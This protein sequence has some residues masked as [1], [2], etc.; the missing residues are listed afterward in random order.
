MMGGAQQTEGT[1][2]ISQGNTGEGTVLGKQEFSVD[3]DDQPVRVEFGEGAVHIEPGE[4]YSI[5][6]EKKRGANSVYYGQHGQPVA[7]SDGSGISFKFHN[8]SKARN[9]GTGVSRGQIPW[10]FCRRP[11]LRRVTPASSSAGDVLQKFE[12]SATLDVNP[13]V[14]C[15]FVD[16]DDFSELLRLLSWAMGALQTVVTPGQSSLA[17]ATVRLC[18]RL[19]MINVPYIDDICGVSAP[20]TSGEAAGRESDVDKRAGLQG[21][22]GNPSSATREVFDSSM[23]TKAEFETEDEDSSVTGEEMDESENDNEVARR[24][25]TS[26]STKT[27]IKV[28]ALSQQGSAGRAATILWE[29]HRLLCS[30][31]QTECG[32]S[33]DLLSTGAETLSCMACSAYETM[34]YALFPRPVNALRALIDRLHE[35][36]QKLA[37]EKARHSNEASTH[38]ALLTSTL[39]SLISQGWGRHLAHAWANSDNSGNFDSK[40]APTDISRALISEALLSLDERDS[41]SRSA[42]SLAREEPAKAIGTCFGSAAELADQLLD[43]VIVPASQALAAVQTQHKEFEATDMHFIG[44]EASCTS[45]AAQLLVDCLHVLT[46]DAKRK[47][48]ENAQRKTADALDK[49]STTKVTAAAK[50]AAEA[51]SMRLRVAR[52]LKGGSSGSWG[53]GGQPDEIQFSLVA[54]PSQRPDATVELAGFGLFGTSGSNVFDATISL[55]EVADGGGVFG[56][57]PAPEFHF[58][59][60]GAVDAPRGEKLAEA[61]VRFGDHREQVDAAEAAGKAD[62]NVF[63][64]MFDD[65]VQLQ[66][67]VTYCAVAHISGQSSD[68]G[69]RIMYETFYDSDIEVDE[70][71][72]KS[73]RRH[74]QVARGGFSFGEVAPAQEELSGSDDDI[75]EYDPGRP[76]S[77]VVGSDGARFIFTN[78]GSNNGTDIN[79]GQIPQLLYRTLIAADATSQIA[80]APSQK[81]PTTELPSAVSG[82]AKAAKGPATPAEESDHWTWNPDDKSRHVALHDDDTS[83][84]KEGG[85]TDG[86]RGTVAFTPAGGGLHSFELHWNCGSGSNSTVGFATSE[87]PTHHDRYVDQVGMDSNGWGMKA[88]TG[89]LL[90]GGRSTGRGSR[91]QQ[92]SYLAVELDLD[93]RPAILR[94]GVR[95]EEE[96]EADT[97]HQMELDV[98]AM[99]DGEDT[100]LF[101]MISTSMASGK[102]ILLSCHSTWPLRDEPATIASQTVRLADY[103]MEAPPAM[104]HTPALVSFCEA[105]FSRTELLISDALDAARTDARSAK[106]IVSNS[107]LI[108]RLL[109]VVAPTL[110]LMAAGVTNMNATDARYETVLSASREGALLAQSMLP[111][112]E[113]LLSQFTAL[114]D[115]TN[116]GVDT[117]EIMNSTVRGGDDTRFEFETP[118]P[119]EPSAVYKWEAH[120][121]ESVHFISVHFD[122]RCST[123]QSCDTL[124]LFSDAGAYRRPIGPAMSGCS[125]DVSKALERLADE[126]EAGEKQDK[127]KRKK[128]KKKKK[129]KKDKKKEGSATYGEENDELENWPDGRTAPVIVAGRHICAEFSSAAQSKNVGDLA[130]FDAVDDNK[131]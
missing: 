66:T 91:F 62:I 126:A 56:G 112:L 11:T 65:P 18:I 131:D 98:D 110:G 45:A 82:Q 30:V 16:V 123:A 17:R 13:Q 22:G 81:V 113:K 122:Q 51:S 115:S 101:P 125:V 73:F 89:D 34:F 44:S 4:K 77:A 9:N 95:S 35:H 15:E 102:V 99:A 23:P 50:A 97:P 94:F 57:A 111:R 5:T 128:K 20:I 85:N 49:A 54:P 6:V 90:H 28:S 7:E 108:K 79:N 24:V 41:H 38:S 93:V 47:A 26:L 76:F 52:R 118:H 109:P 58:G 39:R 36:R 43:L 32:N 80:A 8:C 61:R 130:V 124:R 21:H 67:G 46:A 127:A 1:I 87:V 104:L 88:S 31:T 120:F 68:S 40:L 3:F 86:A 70:V 92:G 27:H 14:M 129:K 78:S 103:A 83:F 74:Q 12:A 19:L 69:S 96:G 37:T 2:Y 53:Y 119:Y 84:F 64:A 121:P 100:E 105:I 42:G 33:S 75:S 116:I 106:L 63:H 71:A 107:P 117:D 114:I 10:I 25:T 59:E 60:G 72:D 55:L 29:V 48:R